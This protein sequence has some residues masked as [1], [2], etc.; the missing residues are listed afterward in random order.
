MLLGDAR[1]ATLGG[2]STINRLPN[3][4]PLISDT[5]R[6]QLGRPKWSSLRSPDRERLRL[7]DYS[8]R[9][10]TKH[11]YTVVIGLIPVHTATD[12]S[13]ITFYIYKLRAL[14]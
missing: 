14:R 7:S 13:C 11:S 8:Y 5:P 2:S 12:T 10:S 9:L 4:R 3:N 6:L 1:K